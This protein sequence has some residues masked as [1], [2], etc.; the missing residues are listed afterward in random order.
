MVA[1]FKYANPFSAVVG[2][3]ITPDDNT[4]ITTLHKGLW[5]GNAGDVR[6][7][8][9]ESGVVTLQGVVSGTLL[10]IRAK[11]VFDTGTT[12]TGIVALQ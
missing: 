10:P 1:T 6:V 4:E 9:W 8:M 11:K 5:V 2:F 12:A 3:E 7:L